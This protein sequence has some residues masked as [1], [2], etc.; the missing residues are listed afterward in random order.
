M[1]T[2]KFTTRSIE[3]LKG[4]DKRY[5]VIETGRHG[6]AVRVSPKGTK[7]WIYCYRF[8]GRFRKMTLGRY[9]KMSLADAHEAHAKAEKQKDHGIDPGEIKV[10]QN[11]E[12]RTKSTVQEM[13]EKYLKE[14][15][16]KRRSA[17]EM[18]RTFETDILP[19]WARKKATSIRKSDVRDVLQVITDRGAPKQANRTFAL[20]RRF[21][22]WG[23]KEDYVEISPCMGLEMPHEETPRKRWLSNDEIK[24]LWLGLDDGKV[25]DAIKL[26]LKLQLVT[27]QRKGEIVTALKSDID[28]EEKAWTI[29]EETTKNKK[30]HIVPLSELA[31]EIVKEALELDPK[32]KWLFPSPLF[33]SK[34]ENLR[35]RSVDH[36]LKKC[37][38]LLGLEDVK[39][40]DLRR[41]AGTNI[42]KLGFTRFIMRRVINHSERASA[43]DVY[44]LYS[45]FSEKELAL[46][47]W[48]RKINEIIT[49]EKQ[50]GNVVPLKA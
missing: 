6:F 26:A 25:A 24:T 15:E 20:I 30:T 39:P 27:G 33:V 4:K 22:N 21:F 46:N 42:T 16:V 1:V 7:S 38:P 31:V 50:Q 49:D 9:P 47:A 32:S 45:Y 2:M 19:H 10:K 13:V 3:S 23:V 44:D 41:T 18:R 36:G 28:L 17:H 35:P 8:E 37:L 11:I 40:H 43:A 5:E 48:A 14:V 29:P 34:D 12:D